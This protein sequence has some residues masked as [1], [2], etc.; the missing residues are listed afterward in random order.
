MHI[1]PLIGVLA[2][3]ALAAFTPAAALGGRDRARSLRLTTPVPLRLTK[4]R[5]WSW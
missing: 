3:G 5:P 1:V 2:A 4:L